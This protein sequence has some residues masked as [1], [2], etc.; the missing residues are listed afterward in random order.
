MAARWQWWQVAALFLAAAA[1]P[2]A[3][4]D[5]ELLTAARNGY[6][7]IVRALLDSGADREVKD[8]DGKTALM[9]AAEK[10]RSLIVRRLRAKGANPGARDKEG[11]TA[12]GL[13]LLSSPAKHGAILAMLPKPPAVRI[14]V[15]AV[16]LPE[17]MV[18]S[19]FLSREELARVI[20]AIHPDALALAAFAKYARAAGKDL[21]EIL[22][23]D[24]EGLKP[25]IPTPPPGDAEATV[26][27]A[28]RPEVSCAGQSD[29]LGLAIDV[30]VIRPG[31]AGPVY[32]K[33]FGG[34]LKGLFARSLTGPAQY[35]PY[36]EKWA[37]S[38]ASS[39]YWAVLP[40]VMGR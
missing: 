38:H 29:N 21:V 35:P 28:V 12:Y 39:I 25:E 16:W 27:L 32:R 23:A 5:T 20:A 15:E 34:G 1:A 14:D 30:R 10:G 19:C 33:T 22:R 24:S 2:A 9:L 26:V 11:L 17:S 36:L 31:N 13:A 8:A 18:S 40:A 37:A 3:E 6:T 4:P 7:S